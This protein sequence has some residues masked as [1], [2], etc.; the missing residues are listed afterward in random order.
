MMPFDETLADQDHAV[1]DDVTVHERL[2]AVEA[3]LENIEK[4]VSEFKELAGKIWTFV[5]QMK[6]NPMLSAMLGGIPKR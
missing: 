4:S 6:D 2:I 5:E 3:R 1:S